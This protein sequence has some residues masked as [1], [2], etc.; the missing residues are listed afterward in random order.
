MGADTG[1]IW[2]IGS[3][4]AWAD[5]V[6]VSMQVT[7]YKLWLGRRRMLMPGNS[8]PGLLSHLLK[9]AGLTLELWSLAS[10]LLATSKEWTSADEN[11]ECF[12][13]SGCSAS[14][15]LFLFRHLIDLAIP[16][17]RESQHQPQFD[18]Q[19]LIRYICFRRYLQPAE[20]WYKE[21]TYQRDYSLPFYNMGK[22][23]PLLWLSWDQLCLTGASLMGS[24]PSGRVSGISQV[25]GGC[26]C[27]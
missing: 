27:V 18:Q 10:N 17:K 2:S 15:F 8:G 23:G 11:M 3:S 24:P 26:A 5:P 14:S 13:S 1:E 6:E 4:H 9:T 19:T 20:Q 22:S 12:S 25:G 21:T 16:P 7:F